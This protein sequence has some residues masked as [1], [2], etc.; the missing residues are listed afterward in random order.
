MS[1]MPPKAAKTCGFFFTT[2][3]LWKWDKVKYISKSNELWNWMQ[4]S[5]P[6]ET[7]LD[8]LNNVC[9]P[10]FP[11]HTSRRDFLRVST[12]ILSLR[13]FTYLTG[14]PL[15][16]AKA[17]SCFDR[18]QTIWVSSKVWFAASIRV[19]QQKSKK[20]PCNDGEILPKT[21]CNEIQTE[22]ETMVHYRRHQPATYPTPRLPWDIHAERRSAIQEEPRKN[23][24][25]F[26]TRE[27]PQPWFDHSIRNRILDHHLRCHLTMPTLRKLFAKDSHHIFSRPWRSICTVRQWNRMNHALRTTKLCATPLL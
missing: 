18:C 17:L 25:N 13:L 1:M 11:H 27:I 16:T 4:W 22:L 2:T 26:W 3:H 10:I 19:T 6:Q 7:R 24:T 5:N 23:N 14:I 8:W 12:L 20:H 15:S 21:G 9:V